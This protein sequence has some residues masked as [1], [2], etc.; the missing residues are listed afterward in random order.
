MPESQSSSVELTADLGAPIALL[1]L[2]PGQRWLNRYTILQHVGAGGMGQVLLAYDE[3]LNRRVALKLLSDGLESQTENAAGLLLQREAQA[4][5]RL[6]HPNVVPVF[7]S[8]NFEDGSVFLAMEFVEGT[9]LNAWCTDRPWKE[10]LRAFL[11]AAKGLAASHAVGLIHRD[12][13]PLNVLVGADGRIRVTDFGISRLTG[14]PEFIGDLTKCQQNHPAVPSAN[15]APL[16]GT[17]K[18]MAP[19]LLAGQPATVRSDVYAFCVALY[20]ALYQSSPV[21]DVKAPPS[22][23]EIPIWLG[24]VIVRGLT[25]DANARYSSMGALIAALQND[26]QVEFRRLTRWAAGCCAAVLCGLFSW[27]NWAKSQGRDCDSLSAG[28]DMVWNSTSRARVRAALSETG[29]SYADAT[30]QQVEMILDDYAERWIDQRSALCEESLE[31]SPRLHKVQ[32]LEEACLERRRHEL[33]A[34]AGMLSTNAD[35]TLVQNAVHAAQS[36]SPLSYCSDERALMAR[37]PPPEEPQLRAQVELLQRE[38]EALGLFGVAGRPDEGL[39]HANPLLFKAQAIGY[40]PL[41]A[42]TLLAVASLEES[43]G[44]YAEAEARARSAIPLAA[45]GGDAVTL[46]KGWLMLNSVVGYRLARFQESSE[47]ELILEAMLAQARNRDIEVSSQIIRAGI[48][49]DRGMFAQALSLYENALAEQ[50][51]AKG[52]RNL[53][54]ASTMVSMG[55]SLVELGRYPQALQ[56]YRQALSI[57]EG[58][59]GPQH[60]DVATTHACL[61]RL[62]LELGNLPQALTHQQQARVIQE[63]AFGNQHPDLA[64]SLTS[65]GLVFSRMGRYPEALEMYQRALSMRIHALGPRHPGVATVLNNIGKTLA[66][67]GRYQEALHHLQSAMDIWLESEGPEH[68]DIAISLT[69]LGAVHFEMGQFARAQAAHQR[70]LTLRRKVLGDG[71]PD[72]ARSLSYLSAAFGS[73]GRGE[74]ALVMMRTA[75]ATQEATIGPQHAHVIDSL[76]A[77]ANIEL[78]LHRPHEAIATLQDALRRSIQESSLSQIADIRF[79]LAQAWWSVGKRDT[80]VITLVE[81][82]QAYWQSI[83]HPRETRA[84]NWLAL[85]RAHASRLSP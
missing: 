73:L 72:T 5:A 44:R 66:R 83:K 29:L 65:L 15:S 4:M 38:V 34:L 77:L 63:R 76:M 12:F 24:R 7:D 68:T 20:E 47:M 55:V 14:E 33:Q 8:G 26:P 78:A 37:V 18:Y 62:F 23:S 27:S 51:R 25:P 84:R 16:V 57:E 45:A 22:A 48:L 2:K 13:K 61:G 9:T 71:H 79:A 35:A 11:E 46:A 19:E 67:S 85:R 70:A 1:S 59:L 31:R 75:L 50:K 21:I 32:L 54:V 49:H 40:A 58:M 3:R 56:L 17:R 6:N 64:V 43:A 30:A 81:Q 60:P 82:A 74:E 53:E 52:E 41:T 10:V 39:Q 36:L 42:Q 28:M 69:N 80:S